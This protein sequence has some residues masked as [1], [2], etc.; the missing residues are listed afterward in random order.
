MLH[1][2]LPPE[3]RI[4]LGQTEDNQEG[5]KAYIVPR[6]GH[7]SVYPLPRKE[8]VET[9]IYPT[10]TLLMSSETAERAGIVGRRVLISL[11]KVC[12]I[13]NP[14][15]YRRQRKPGKAPS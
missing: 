7:V 11:E 14:H 6:S 5:R 2:N 13:W 3:V 10:G 8:A 1:V 9:I 4:H 12:K 15:Q